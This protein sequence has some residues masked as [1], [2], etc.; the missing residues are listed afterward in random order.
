MWPFRIEKGKWICTAL[1]DEMY[2][3]HYEPQCDLNVT[4]SGGERAARADSAH[5]GGEET[6]LLTGHAHRRNTSSPIH[7]ILQSTTELKLH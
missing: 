7:S 4:H 1:V 5:S 6:V 2:K 3:L